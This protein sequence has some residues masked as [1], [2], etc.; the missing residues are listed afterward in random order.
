MNL[1]LFGKARRAR[2]RRHS[3]NTIHM[4][5]PYHRFPLVYLPDM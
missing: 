3:M 4:Y 5:D 1:E 2:R